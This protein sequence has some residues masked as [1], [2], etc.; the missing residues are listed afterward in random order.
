MGNARKQK[1]RCNKF[2]HYR[3]RENLPRK[4]KQTRITD[5][6][7]DA[8]ENRHEIETLSIADGYKLKCFQLNSQK[9]LISTENIYNRVTKLD[10]FLLL[11]QEPSVFGHNIIGLNKRHTIV[12]AP[13]DKPRAYIYCHKALNAWPVEELCTRDSAACI[14][15]TNDPKTGRILAVSI[16]WDGTLAIPRAIEDAMYFARDNNYTLVM[17]GDMNA[18]NTLWPRALTTS[19]QN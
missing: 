12:Q 4:S 14:I 17:A 18:R 6:F 19:H 16:Y 8:E 11:G 13:V 2:A 5:F 3:N 15:D 7:N 1:L 9:R 10:S